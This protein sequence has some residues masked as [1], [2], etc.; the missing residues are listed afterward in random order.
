M[1]KTKLNV[2]KYK[3]DDK[4]V[5]WVLDS[6][7]N[8]VKLLEEYV[9]NATSE[10]C[11][12][13]VYECICLAE[14]MLVYLCDFIEG[15]DLLKYSEDKSVIRDFKNKEDTFLVKWLES[16]F[17]ERFK[18][19]LTKDMKSVFYTTFNYLQ[20]TDFWN[21]LEKENIKKEKDK[22]LKQMI[23]ISNTEEDSEKKANKIRI[24]E[25]KY[26][27]LEKKEGD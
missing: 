16:R 6:L 12:S 13:T 20:N 1:M 26:R 17:S 11:V 21:E 19:G 15:Y 25:E 24:L 10:Y 9:G 18:E 8:K 23:H 2:F 27:E 7:K 14:S 5:K 22:L 4:K 3:T